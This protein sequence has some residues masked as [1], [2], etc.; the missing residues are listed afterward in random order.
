MD[1]TQE[2]VH[3]IVLAQRAFFRSGKTLDVSSN[4]R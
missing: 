3:D 2:R 4:R 1:Y